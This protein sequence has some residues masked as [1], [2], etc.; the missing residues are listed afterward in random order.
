MTFEM[1]FNLTLNVMDM[2]YKEDKLYIKD[3]LYK[4]DTLNKEDTLKNIMYA[5][6]IRYTFYI[7]RYTR[8][9]KAIDI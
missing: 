7:L 9:P 3:V 6:R 2:L 8:F 1:T 5:R 4:K